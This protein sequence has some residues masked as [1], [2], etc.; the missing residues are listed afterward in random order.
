M[1][2]AVKWHRRPRTW[3]ELFVLF[4][5]A[6]LAPDI[7]LAH[8]TNNFHAAAEYIPL[9]FS[10]VAPVLL[11]L[12][13]G[14]LARSRLQPW[15]ALGYLVGWTSVIIGITGMVLHLKS[16]FFQQWTLASLVYAAPFAAPLAY[17]GLG[18]LLLMNRMVED[19]QADWPWWVIFFALGGF[20]GNFVFSLTDHAQNGFFHHTEW[21]PVI[22]SAVAVGFLVVTLLLPVNRTY[23]AVCGLVLL[24]QTAVGALGFALH[25]SADWHGVG[26]TLL[27]RVI[28]G[29]PIFAPTLFCD[30]AMLAGIGLWEFWHSQRPAMPDPPRPTGI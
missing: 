14:S 20:A 19:D 3:V 28:H 13:I 12:A 5:L 24:A 8:S 16:Q 7:F 18:S 21:I 27:A 2:P 6:G 30:L 11:V 9:V 10:L 25:A 22:S 29:A 1:R 15:R 26:P 23:L 4:N 17:T